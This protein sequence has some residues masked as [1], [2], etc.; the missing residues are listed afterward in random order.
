MINVLKDNLNKQLESGKVFFMDQKNDVTN[1][2]KGWRN[3]NVK[4]N[5][6]LGGSHGWTSS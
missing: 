6:Y 5:S 3:I 1:M 4:E 2:T